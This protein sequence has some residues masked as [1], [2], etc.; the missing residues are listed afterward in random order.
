MLV[1]K[2]QNQWICSCGNWV[3]RALNWCPNCCEEQEGNSEDVAYAREQQSVV[4][5]MTHM[6]NLHFG[7]ASF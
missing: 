6:S 5:S 2:L 1:K 3:G 7:G 4:K